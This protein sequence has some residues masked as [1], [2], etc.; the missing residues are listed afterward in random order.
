LVTAVELGL[1]SD[2][3]CTELDAKAR[4]IDADDNECSFDRRLPPFCGCPEDSYPE[5]RCTHCSDGTSI[6]PDMWS[7]PTFEDS[8]CADGLTIWYNIEADYEA[9]PDFQPQNS[10]WCGCE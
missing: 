2:L 4:E 10:K 9:C 1:K 7:T 5:D 8:T 6:S 3:T